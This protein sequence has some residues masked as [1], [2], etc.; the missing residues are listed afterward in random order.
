MGKWAVAFFERER[1]DCG[2]AV[3]SGKKNY[4]YKPILNT[5]MQKKFIL[6][7]PMVKILKRT[8]QNKWQ[9]FVL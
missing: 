7:F 4:L 6:L 5:L 2:P 9:Y 8:N 3:V 1:F